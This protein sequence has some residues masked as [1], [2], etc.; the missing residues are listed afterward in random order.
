MFEP[1]LF[2]PGYLR[3]SGQWVYSEGTANVALNGV[4]K[5]V[6]FTTPNVDFVNPNES[7]TLQKMCLKLFTLVKR[8]PWSLQGTHLLQEI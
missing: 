5:K 8:Q 4:T 7:L 3:R 1:L 2:A 6:D